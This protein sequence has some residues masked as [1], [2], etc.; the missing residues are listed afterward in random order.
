MKELERM[1]GIWYNIHQSSERRAGG[2]NEKMR[3]A[4]LRQT[5]C[6]AP[7]HTWGE[8][9]RGI[10]MDSFMDK[11][12]Q[13]FSAQD[14]IRANS[15]AEEKEMKRLRMQVEEYDARL[16]EI[17]KLNLK[18][19]ELADNLQAMID[20]GNAR[21]QES[22]GAGANQETEAEREIRA[23]LEE[24]KVKLEEFADRLMTQ[25]KQ[26]TVAKLETMEKL[27][28]LSGRLCDR[29]V[30]DALAE[31]LDNRAALDTILA[32]LDDRTAWE[33]FSAKLDSRPTLDE[34]EER[35]K[36]R[37]AE[38]G[39]AGKLEEIN[40][41]LTDH[42]HKENVKVYRNVQAAVIDENKKLAEALA[43]PQAELKAQLE[44]VNKKVGGL[45]ALVAVA[46]LASLAN[47][48]LWVLNMFDLLP[49]F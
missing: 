46:L 5:V 21:L 20:A 7:S 41:Q 9:A 30:L 12:A 39:L 25:T 17:R 47:V 14:M 6:E 13:K 8:R 16:Q 36:E 3:W 15:A 34:I 2:R 49:V 42:V 4:A 44:G 45:K 24:N 18:N 23:M 10:R 33:A 11:I 35:L 38:G 43:V 31:R 27:D 26:L 32:K 29:T 28:A 40:T 22:A 19:L 48:A 1:A 37:P